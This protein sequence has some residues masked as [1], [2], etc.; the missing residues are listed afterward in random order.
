[1]IRLRSLP[2]LAIAILA[3]GFTAWAELASVGQSSP[4]DA[5]AAAHGGHHSAARAPSERR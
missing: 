4:F 2:T 5:P 3:L 1:M